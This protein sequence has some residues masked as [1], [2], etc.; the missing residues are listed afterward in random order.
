MVK[1]LIRKRDWKDNSGVS[2]V[3]G[4]I[5]I[6]LMTVLLFSGIILWVWGLPTPSPISAI[7]IDT[8]FNPIDDDM[9]DPPTWDRVF[10]NLT[11][12]GGD[13]LLGVVT[14][15]YLV[16]NETSEVLKTSGISGEGEPYDI[17]GPDKD[18]NIGEVWRYKNYSIEY[19]HKVKITLVDTY[20]SVVLWEKNL[21]G[22]EGSRPPIFVDKWTDG[23]PPP[24]GTI[25]RDPVE[26]NMTDIQTGEQIP[27]GIFTKIKDM[28]GDLNK[29]SVYVNFTFGPLAGNE[30]QMVD[31]GN[32]TLCDVKQGDDVFSLCKDSFWPGADWR[33]WDYGKLLL[34]ATDNAGHKTTTRLLLRVY[35]YGDTIH[36]TIH[37]NTT[38]GGLPGEPLEYA[39]FE[40]VEWVAYGQGYV[41]TN[42]E[43]RSDEYYNRSVHIFNWTDTVHVKVLSNIL[44]NAH[45]ANI[46]RLYDA[47]TGGAL[48][49]PSG[50]T[51]THVGVVASYHKYVLNFT[52]DSI[53]GIDPTKGGCY[54]VY[55][56]IRDTDDD[57]FITHSWFEVKKED[58]TLA[59]CPHIKLYKDSSYTTESKFF[60]SWDYMYVEIEPAS[61]ADTSVLT[62]TVEFQDFW[63]GSQIRSG[64]ISYVAT[65]HT[66]GAGPVTGICIAGT[67]PD[68]TY[69]LRIDLLKSDKD[70]WLFGNASY[71]LYL[72]IFTD[73]NEYYEN[74]NINMYINSPASIMDIVSGQNKASN[75]AQ[76]E[77]YY[78]FF[79]ENFGGWWEPYPYA[80][81]GG[82]PASDDTIGPIYSVAFADIDGD[83]DKDIVTGS[84]G[85]GSA[86]KD[87]Y[88][89]IWDNYDGRGHFSRTDL[90]TYN[91][92]EDFCSVAVGD[93]NGDHLWDIVAGTTDGTIF[94]YAND[95]SWDRTSTIATGIGTPTSASTNG[96]HGIL[97]ANMDDDRFG[98]VVVVTD[99]G[100]YVYQNK[101][102]D[103]G[104]NW[105]LK[106][107]DAPGNYNGASVAVGDVGYEIA[108]NNRPDIAVGYTN[109][110]SKVYLQNDITDFEWYWVEDAAHSPRIAAVG[111]GDIDGQG[112]NDVVVGNGDDI[113][114][115]VTNVIDHGT[116]WSHFNNDDFTGGSQRPNAAGA[117]GGNIISIQVGNID[118][119]IEDDIAIS[120]T[121]GRIYFYR[122]IRDGGDWKRF[123][124]DDLAARL[125]S[126]VD[127]YSIYIGDMNL[128]NPIP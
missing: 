92:Q 26:D 17:T 31:N 71:T 103:Y 18:W 62:I 3:V 99:D 114:I 87:S 106:F 81:A 6:L 40:E 7:D 76:T 82:T 121:N 4:S 54:N 91:N 47:T 102:N 13:E 30:Y 75:A 8:D 88:L 74:M 118:G 77:K 28:D 94:Y 98:E 44:D 68:Q 24:N 84:A 90:D 52:A 97:I 83:S 43:N 100:L 15:F 112:F 73:A 51:F 41:I 127:I 61:L 79:Y 58:G 38:T 20:R 96:G 80:R 21:W 57:Y 37:E 53:Q 67:I 104:D 113:L 66:G 45:K 70:A 124:V 65:C 78:G 128:G 16:V 69:R 9:D 86:P 105:D 12:K 107:S 101:T 1:R 23:N 115:Y 5:L 89:I 111:I 39:I 46:F 85:S 22:Y 116:S 34:N 108:E 109:G 25:T 117:I 123:I 10:I 48:T 2:E 60:N 72:R 35:N 63:G 49:P 59:A 110:K 122:N 19:H 119:A 93:V 56:E 29:D 14:E 11:H 32:T 36:Q 125:G 33:D 27:F 126:A 64:P 95:G 42:T 50:M 120:T 55:I